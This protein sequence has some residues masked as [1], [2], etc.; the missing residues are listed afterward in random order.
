MS[1]DPLRAAT[2]FFGGRV[3]LDFANTL[4]WRT[5]SEPQE[6]IPDYNSFVSWSV[7]RGTLTSRTA[8]RLRTLAKVTP[9]AAPKMMSD[10]LALRAEIWRMADALREDEPP[11]LELLNAMIARLP[12][13]PPV[14]RH[15][16]GYTYALGGD[17]L[18][19]PLWPILWSLTAVL[20]STD[21]NRIGCCHAEG[22]G[23][24]YVDESPNRTRLWCSSEVCGN[25]ER[26]RRAYAKRRPKAASRI[27]S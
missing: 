21:A 18:H 17:N 1:R 15:R 9:T 12:S 8:A 5:S 20:T 23:W 4:D 27:K 6:L 13:Q 2:Q 26:A 25:R 22:C 11:D 10:A 24:F 19:E 16:G 3:C 7:R 14:S